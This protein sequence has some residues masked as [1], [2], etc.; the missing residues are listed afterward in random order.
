LAAN[1]LYGSLPPDWGNNS[2]PSYLKSLVALDLSANYLSGIMPVTWGTLNGTL[3][4]LSL[5]YNPGLCGSVPLGLPCFT[6][7]GTDFGEAR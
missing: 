2:L 6:A 4:C 1:N 3:N 7:N 5:A